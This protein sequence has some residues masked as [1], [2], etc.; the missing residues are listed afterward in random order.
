M[1]APLILVEAGY[2]RW[3]IMQPRPDFN[4]PIHALGF[5]GMRDRRYEYKCEVQGTLDEALKVLHN[6]EKA[7]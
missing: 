1:N 5:H 7:K 6:L 4:E 3:T 2:R